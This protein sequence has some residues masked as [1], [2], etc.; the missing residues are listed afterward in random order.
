M[1]KSLKFKMPKTGIALLNKYVEQSGIA[2]GEELENE[3]QTNFIF[4][5]ND[6][7][8]KYLRMP[9][10]FLQKIAGLDDEGH[11]T[12]IRFYLADKRKFLCAFMIDQD[13]QIIERVYYQR[14]QRF[15]KASRVKE[16]YVTAALNKW[17]PVAA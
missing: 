9:H 10:C 14:E 13:G 1:L 3:V 5:K 4:I 11:L 12:V 17:M 6:P 15:V 7:R 2:L 16:C 8:L